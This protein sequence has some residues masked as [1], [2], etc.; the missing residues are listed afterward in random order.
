MTFGLQ[1]TKNDETK[2]HLNHFPSL[3]NWI[4]SHQGVWWRKWWTVKT[5]TLRETAFLCPVCSVSKL[6]RSIS[7]IY[8]AK[9]SFKDT[10]WLKCLN[11]GNNAIVR[12][13][14]NF[15]FS[16]G[17][18][19]C[20]CKENEMHHIIPWK[21]CTKYILSSYTSLLLL[22]TKIRFEQVPKRL[23]FKLWYSSTTINKVKYVSCFF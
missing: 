16:E 22:E 18:N 9:G 11:T 20:F 8:L 17:K 3:N 4:Q 13:Y 12:M 2:N 23:I 10:S 14:E 7:W 5:R 15:Q 19:D 1:N 6:V 21:C